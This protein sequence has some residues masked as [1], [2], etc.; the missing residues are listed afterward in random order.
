MSPVGSSPEH[1][2]CVFATCRPPLVHLHTRLMQAEGRRVSWRHGDSACVRCQMQKESRRREEVRG[3]PR[4][5]PS[6]SSSHCSAPRLHTAL[7][8]GSFCGC[9]TQEKSCAPLSEGPRTAW[10][11]PRGPAADLASRWPASPRR[12][13]EHAQPRPTESV[14]ASLLILWGSLHHAARGDGTI[15]QTGPHTV[16][17]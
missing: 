1:R 6:G 15:A 11:R 8:L 2:P 14:T 16:A 3:S 10:T 13:R 7:R 5:P 17:A 12:P 4:W 9:S